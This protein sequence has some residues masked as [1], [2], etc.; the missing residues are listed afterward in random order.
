L[1]ERE[2]GVQNDSTTYIVPGVAFAGDGHLA[3][4]EVKGGH[5]ILPKPE[6]LSGDV[7]FVGGIGI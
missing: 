5:E 4:L 3:T 6:E 1:L 2:S 7:D